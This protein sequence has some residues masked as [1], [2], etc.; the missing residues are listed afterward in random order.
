[1]GSS[2]RSS[3]LVRQRLLWRARVELSFVRLM[4]QE[5]EVSLL[6]AGRRVLEVIYL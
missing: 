4:Y 5:P 2:S 3:C 1:M 6:P